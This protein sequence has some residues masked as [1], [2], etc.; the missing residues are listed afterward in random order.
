MDRFVLVLLALAAVG[1]LAS[2][3]LSKLFKRKW[4]WFFPSL[5]G[6]IIFIYYFWQLEYG[7]TEG[8]QALG[9]FLLML[10]AIAVVVGNVIA[11]IV[12]ALRRKKQKEEK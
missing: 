4:I 6:V 2:F 10:M 3:L 9:Y 1:A 7:K 5:I 11:N 8:F 12:I